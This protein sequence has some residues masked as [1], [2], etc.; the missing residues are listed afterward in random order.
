MA[1]PLINDLEDE[2]D[3]LTCRGSAS[4]S[5]NSSSRMVVPIFNYLEDEVDKPLCRSDFAS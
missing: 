5:A 2:V 1:V 4:R 3:N